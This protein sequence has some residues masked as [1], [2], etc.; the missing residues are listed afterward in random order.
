MELQID[1]QATI[2]TVRKKYGSILEFC[3]QANC[4]SPFFYLILAG[5]R[6]RGGESKKGPNPTKSADVLQRLRD[7]ELL[8]Y[9]QVA[10]G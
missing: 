8:V 7:E 10:N 5:K 1:N 9:K 3:R 2:E 6:G 4:D